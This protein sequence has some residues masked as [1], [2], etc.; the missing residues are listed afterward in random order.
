MI[1]TYGFRARIEASE[2]GGAYVTVPFDV[3]AARIASAVEQVAERTPL[4]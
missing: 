3:E 4:R 1:E 2:G